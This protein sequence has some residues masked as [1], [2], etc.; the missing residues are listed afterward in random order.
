MNIPTQN[1]FF[2]DE[3]FYTQSQIMV[4]KV[5]EFS[6]ESLCFR[7]GMV[8]S[9]HWCHMTLLDHVTPVGG[10]QLGY[11]FLHHYLTLRVACVECFIRNYGSRVQK[12][13]LPNKISSLTQKITPTWC[14]YLSYSGPG[15]DGSEPEIQQEI[16]GPGWS[17]YHQSPATSQHSNLPVVL[18]QL[19]R[20]SIFSTQNINIKIT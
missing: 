18:F 19:Y 10:W 11:P 4:E 2:S 15:T 6:A 8:T 9:G 7:Q 16:Q 3:T 1:I 5:P 20:S 14:L 12:H 17:V 13:S